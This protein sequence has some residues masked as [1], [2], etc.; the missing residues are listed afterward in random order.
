MVVFKWVWLH[1]CRR[2]QQQLFSC[3]AG[4][5]LIGY[6]AG[7]VSYHGRCQDKLLQLENSHLADAIRHRRRGGSVWSDVYV[8]QPVTFSLWFSIKTFVICCSYNTNKYQ[9]SSINLRD[10]IVLQAE[11]D[12]HCDKLVVDCWSSEVSSAQFTDDGPVYH[13][14]G[15]ECRAELQ[16]EILLF[17]ELPEF[18]YNTVQLPCQKP[19]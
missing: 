12:D 2:C 13:A 19:A 6:I 17:L 3:C 10:G 16:R 9:L 7:K 5:A 18:F 14:L 1:M 11:L 15:V 8:I 4:A